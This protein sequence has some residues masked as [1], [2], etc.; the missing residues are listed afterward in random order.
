MLV[1]RRGNEAPGG[2][3]DMVNGL[4]ALTPISSGES[5]APIGK[6]SETDAIPCVDVLCSPT[7]PPEDGAMS[8]EDI[9]G[10]EWGT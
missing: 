7:Q 3:R 10:D 5:P 8:S 9:Q 4:T 6:T 2:P 1:S